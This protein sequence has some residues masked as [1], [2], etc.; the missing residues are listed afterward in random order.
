MVFKNF[1]LRSLF[2]FLFILIY[3]L[4]AFINF[5]FVFYLILLVYFLI[6]FEIYS[7]FKA[8]KF[9]PTIYILVSLLFFLNLDF[10]QISFINF[11]FFILIVVTF[12]IFSYFCGKLIGVNK[13]IKIS[14]NK[15]IE[16]LLG[17]IAFSYIF[18]FLF[19]NYIK[20]NID[21]K[22]IFFTSLIIISAFFGDILESYFKRKNN[23]KNSSEIIPGHGGVFDRFDSFLFAIIIYSVFIN[24]KL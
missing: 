6:F 11:N 22:L 17:G 18:I 13:L 8:Y 16:G 24:L 14:P 9:I 19:S 15:T 4:I 7:N 3:L 2:S 12:D 5:Y 10:N 21:L 23:L 20:L 1:F